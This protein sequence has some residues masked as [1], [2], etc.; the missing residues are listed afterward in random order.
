MENCEERLEKLFLL[1]EKW[2]GKEL[3]VQIIDFLD[4]EAK[5]D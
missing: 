4:G 1:K 3:Q 2:T 5:F